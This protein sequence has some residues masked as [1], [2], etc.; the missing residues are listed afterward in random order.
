MPRSPLHDTHIAL[1]A[2]FVE[3]G[4]WEMPIQYES[5]ISEHMAVRQDC[6]WFDV[7]HLGRFLW[8]GPGAAEAIR[9][10]L[11][12]DIDRIDPGRSQYSLMLN[13]RGGVIDDLIVW[14]W[15]EESF[16][17]LPNASNSDRVIGIFRDLA[18]SVRCDD[19]REQT[20]AIAL[21]GPRAPEVL[22]SLLTEVTR[23]RTFEAV[24]E[25]SAVRGAGTG[26]TGERGGE[27]VLDRDAA[28]SFVESLGESGSTP[29]GLGARDTLR[30][31][32]G[33]PLWGNELDEDTT[34][35][36]AGLG[37]AVSFDHDFRGIQALERQRA[38]GIAK[39]LVGFRLP[40]RR[41]PRHGYRLR[42]RESAGTVTSGN[43]SPI[44]ECGIGMGY[45]S[46]PSD[47]PIECEIRGTWV[48]ADRV[49]PPFV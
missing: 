29:C 10:L 21:Q 33:L 44:L 20:A 34:P 38:E 41:I 49:E 11:S 5:V 4:G 9:Y 8:E 42:A 36:E 39:T 47:A 48:P 18:P 37:F 25:G 30:L 31:E 24:F 26:Y 15:E 14:R 1:G 2:K 35:L 6:G 16:W 12:N 28:A 45:L 40:D 23:F 22:A 32:A 19:L 27:L 17:I 46:P 13:D 7:S 43:F 3:F